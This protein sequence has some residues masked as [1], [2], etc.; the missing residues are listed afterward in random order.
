MQFPVAS[1][2]ASQLKQS[3]FRD[4]AL[5]CCKAVTCRTQFSLM[6]CW[7]MPDTQQAN[8]AVWV[9]ILGHAMLCSP[10]VGGCRSTT[11]C[12]CHFLF[13][14]SMPH[15]CRS[16]SNLFAPRTSMRFG[17][18]EMLGIAEK[19]Q[20]E[21]QVQLVPALGRHQSTCLPD[22]LMLSAQPKSR[23]TFEAVQRVSKADDQASHGQQQISHAND[24]YVL[25]DTVQRQSSG[26][27][28]QVPF[29]YM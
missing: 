2:V 14:L 23:K 15:S 4:A 29:P 19:P 26:V 3:T 27:S 25:T 17:L 7:T 8:Q 13:N 12:L 22:R 6:H 18:V 9:Q 1:H 20:S 10:E 5:H 16:A 21:V 11:R 24:H 28:G